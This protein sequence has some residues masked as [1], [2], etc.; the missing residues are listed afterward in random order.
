M[1]KL[2]DI[3]SEPRATST[4]KGINFQFDGAHVAYTSADQGGAASLLNE[5]FLLKAKNIDKP[6]EEQLAILSKVNEEFTPLHKQLSDTQPPSSVK[7]DTGE[8]KMT[9]GNKDLMSVEKLEKALAKIEALEKNLSIE[10]ASNQIASYEF[11]ESE[12]VAKALADLSDEAKDV[13]LKSYAELVSAKE[14]AVTKAVEAAKV[15]AP[16]TE[17]QKSLSEEAG[18]SGE[19]EVQ[20]ELSFVDKANAAYEKLNKKGD[21]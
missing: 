5:P 21:K 3:Q 8:T 15:E 20:A 19:A 11:T 1:T 16:E 14:E 12:E 17:L 10:K 7:S 4:L 2:K 6:S 18:D 9:K 13:V